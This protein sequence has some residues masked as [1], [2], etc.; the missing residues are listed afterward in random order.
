MEISKRNIESWLLDF[1]DGTLSPQQERKL[2]AFLDEHPEIELQPE[3]S[4]PTIGVPDVEFEQIDK[5][6]FEEVKKRAEGEETSCVQYV[7]GDIS[8]EALKT[9][10]EKLENSDRL[11]G[12]LHLYQQSKLRPDENEKYAFKEVLKRKSFVGAILPKA[13]PVIAVAA[14]VCLIILGNQHWHEFST[15]FDSNQENTYQPRRIIKSPIE[16][17]QLE[18][19]DLDLPVA[20]NKD[21]ITDNEPS[22]VLLASEEP[23][24][25][26]TRRSV[27][28]PARSNKGTREA[29]APL[30]AESVTMLNG[31][32]QVQSRGIVASNQPVN[33]KNIDKIQDA[34]L[35]I[36]KEELPS[37]INTKEALGLGLADKLFGENIDLEK[38]DKDVEVKFKI[39]GFKFSKT[40]SEK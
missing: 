35:G 6:Y 36:D 5:L 22:K 2:L 39:A 40:I 18:K 31:G 23:K 17:I 20:E 11:L 19:Q 21:T 30:K 3:K 12:K 29:M 26:V 27:Q 37:N 25:K 33:K 13:W 32:S 24:K 38:K 9:F 10:E 16:V 7:E 15:L 14:S 8:G 28:K 1:A 4:L 34:L